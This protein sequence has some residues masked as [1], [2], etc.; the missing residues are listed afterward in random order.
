MTN[1]QEGSKAMINKQEE[2]FY[3]FIRIRLNKRNKTNGTEHSANSSNRQPFL[4]VQT[5]TMYI[6]NLLQKRR[7]RWKSNSIYLTQLA[8]LTRLTTLKKVYLRELLDAT[9][10]NHCLNNHNRDLQSREEGMP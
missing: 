10:I 9:K 8:A 5:P 4:S 7:A 6:R 2:L 1:E 3:A